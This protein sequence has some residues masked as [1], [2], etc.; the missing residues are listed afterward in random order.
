MDDAILPIIDEKFVVGLLFFGLL[1]DVAAYNVTPVMVR[2]T[3]PEMNVAAWTDDTGGGRQTKVVRNES[4][5]I[6]K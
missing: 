3:A 4:H 5:P 1:L 2:P 6:E